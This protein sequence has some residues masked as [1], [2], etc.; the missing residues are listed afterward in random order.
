MEQIMAEPKSKPDP[1]TNGRAVLDEADV[2]SGERSPGQD[3]TDEMIRQ[4]PRRGQG[5]EKQSKS[6]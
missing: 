1:E 4:I 3:E 2:G 5:E 6:E